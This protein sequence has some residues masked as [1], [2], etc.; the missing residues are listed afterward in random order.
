MFDGDDSPQ[1]L[2]YQRCVAAFM[3]EHHGSLDTTVLPNVLVKGEISGEQRQVDVLIDR[4]WQGGAA[5]RIIVDAKKRSRKLDIGDVEQFEGMLRDCRAARGIMVCTAGSTS[6]AQK[7]AQQAITITVLDF[8]EALEFDWA[9]E[10]AWDLA[11]QARVVGTEAF[12]GGK[13][14]WKDY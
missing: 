13:S 3:S 10:N 2:V 4:R 7:R 11:V 9:Y 12:C 5:S 14:W 1:W 6:G 8:E